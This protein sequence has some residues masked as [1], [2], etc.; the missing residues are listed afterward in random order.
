MSKHWRY[1][2]LTISFLFLWAF[3]FYLG[4]EVVDPEAASPIFLGAAGTFFAILIGMAIYA[5]GKIN[6]RYQR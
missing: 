6:G 4:T 1:T 5:W 2:F 3:G